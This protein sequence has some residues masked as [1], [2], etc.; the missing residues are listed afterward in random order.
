M[1][2][3]IGSLILNNFNIND[4]KLSYN[5][6]LSKGIIVALKNIFDNYNEIKDI[7]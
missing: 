6:L 1:K 7:F 3:I 4:C 2:P 5:G